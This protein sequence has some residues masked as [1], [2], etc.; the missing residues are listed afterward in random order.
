MKKY[1]IERGGYAKA[2]AKQQIARVDFNKVERIAIIR[3]AALG[4]LI[5][6]RAFIVEAKRLFPNAKIVLSVLS[7]YKIGMPDDL[8]D[9]IHVV[10][11]AREKKLS[12]LKT[13]KDIQGLGQFDFV[14]DLSC[15]ARSRAFLM[16]AQCRFKVGFPYSVIEQRVFH[17][18]CVLRSD[19]STELNCCIDQLRVF[20][21]KPLVTPN[22]ALEV[23]EVPRLGAKQAKI[24]W[25]VGAS[26]VKKQ[27][28][29]AT[30]LSSIKLV[31]QRYPDAEIIF[32]EGV[33]KEEKADF[34]S[35]EGIKN[36]RVVEAGS[37]ESLRKELV[38]LDVLVSPDTGV[39][40]LAITT[41]TP[42]LGIFMCTPVHRYWPQINGLHQV[43]YQLDGEHPSAELIV[44][45]LIDH[46]QELAK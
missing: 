32:Y 2:S 1:W 38:N 8:V 44:D 27:F 25:F 45:G 10:E 39:R 40:N 9:E 37:L 35:S 4:D 16:F 17:D 14:F 13:R 15:T 29:R 30:C 33:G 3:Y 11:T 42:T 12:L 41:H 23:N 21:H 28:D 46:L 43:V 6:V 20:G 22:F 26:T 31:N 5:L 7:H 36:L 34:L 19:L 24:G 18:F